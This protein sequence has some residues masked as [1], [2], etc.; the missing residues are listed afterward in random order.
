MT[1][2]L[3]GLSANHADVWAC[4][5]VSFFCDVALRHIVGEALS[6]CESELYR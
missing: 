2:S 1:D 5:A 3:T 4:G 6:F